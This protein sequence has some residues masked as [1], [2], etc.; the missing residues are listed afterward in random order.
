M[1]PFYVG[2]VKRSNSICFVDLIC[3]LCVKK[4]GILQG[5]QV[6]TP[7]DGFNQPRVELFDVIGFVTSKIYPAISGD[8]KYNS[9]HFL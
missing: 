7:S 9:K 4:I 2:T 1:F 6:G 5:I 8:A 3:F